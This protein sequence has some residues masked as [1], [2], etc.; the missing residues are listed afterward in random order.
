M[1]PKTYDIQYMYMSCMLYMSDIPILNKY[2]NGHLRF[3]TRSAC[4]HGGL[5]EGKIHG[6]PADTGVK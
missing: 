3:P 6:V 1:Y 2:N 4:K 5:Y